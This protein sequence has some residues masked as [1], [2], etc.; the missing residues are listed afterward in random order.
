MPKHHVLSL[1]PHL[2]LEWRG[3][4]GQDETEKSNHF[5]SLGDSIASSTRTGFSVHSGRVQD[6]GL[7][8]KIDRS[9]RSRACNCILSKLIA[10]AVPL[11]SHNRNSSYACGTGVFINEQL[12][13]S[14]LTFGGCQ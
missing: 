11:I 4:R 14:V 8:S 13:L 10:S 2:R 3:Q 7:Q 6:M 1:K 5:V 12:T 9:S